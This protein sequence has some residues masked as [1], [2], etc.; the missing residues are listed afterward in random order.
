MGV[1]DAQRVLQDINCIMK[2]RD[3]KIITPEI[4]E[5]LRAGDQ[6]AFE[7]IY[8]RYVSS[9]RGF[10]SALVYSDEIGTE[11]TQDSFITLWEKR[12]N[13]DPTGNISGY[14]YTIAKNIALKFLNRRKQHSNSNSLLSLTDN[15]ESTIATD[16]DIT[17]RDIELLIEIALENMP[18]KRREVYELSRKE[19]LSNQDI[20]D[21][22]QI[23]KNT[24]EN[25]LVSALKHIRDKI[26]G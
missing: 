5:A 4:L 3:S 1:A 19:G 26:G 18:A 7:T 14:L 12:E 15:I 25:H 10:L 11:L 13:I 6:Q 21:R 17:K 22:L 23:S 24:V 16:Q 2:N 20:A 8:L 9:I